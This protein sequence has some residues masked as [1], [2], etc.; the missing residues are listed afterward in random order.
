MESIG[1]HLRETREQRGLNVDQIAR[2]TNIS[3]QYIVALEEDRYDAFPGEPYV[4]GFLRNYSDH[5]G[6]DT[7][8]LIS[9]YRTQK[10]QEQPAPLEELI[11]KPSPWPQRVVWGGGAL[12]VLVAIIVFVIP[13]IFGFL[14][15]LPQALA[16]AGPERQAKTYTLAEKDKNLIQRLFVGDTV[17]VALGSQTVPLKLT[18]VGDESALGDY[19]LHLGDEVFLDLD[20]DGTQDVRVFLK[21]VTPGDPNRGAEFAF[22]RMA[23]PVS[24]VASDGTAGDEL[25]P[26][27][28]AA[29][30]AT[31]PPDDQKPVV[32]LTDVPAKPFT[33]DVVFRGY[34]LFRYVV[35]DNRR[36]ENYFHK[37][38]TVRIDA[39]R[40]VKV[41]VSNA[42]AFSGKVNQAADFEIG[43]GGEVVARSIE[44]S[45][46]ST[47][48]TILVA[49]PMN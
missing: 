25:K 14:A 33:V 42:G 38:D 24:T 5:L 39:S 16:A 26:G 7:E 10:I 44:W 20:Q 29:G 21:D 17:S 41:W 3:R 31:A 22:E 32:I 37:G 46:D 45:K 11:R 27:L 9:R 47:G 40:K 36:E 43:H 15:S 4:V 35:D 2:E 48:K 1:K 23:A 13:P 30:T 12:V 8:G 19:R 28:A 18:A 6:L 49:L 34:A